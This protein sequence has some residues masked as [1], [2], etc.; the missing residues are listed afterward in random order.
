MKRYENRIVAYIDVLGFKNQIRSTITDGKE[1]EGQTKLIYDAYNSI[2]DVWNLDSKD[3]II[4]KFHK[5]KR[6][7]IFSDS[8]VVSVKATEQSALFY[9]LLEIMWLIMQL[10]DKKMLCRGAIVYGKLHHT[11]KMIFGPALVDAYITESKAALYPR[12][13][14]DKSVIE[15]GAKYGINDIQYERESIKNLL[16]MDTDGLYYIEYFS[17]IQ[18][19]LDVPLYDYPCYLEKLRAIITKGIDKSNPIDLQ[20]KY[21]WMVDKFNKIVTEI[22]APNVIDILRETEDPE[23]VE[24]YENLTKISF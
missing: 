5:S 10:I 13:I 1:I 20:I 17:K 9:M 6:I 19:E 2:R 23:L 8:I 22:S 7:T 4:K 24:Y 21:L 14:L 18:G 16:A 12:I 11:Q 3:P 15:I